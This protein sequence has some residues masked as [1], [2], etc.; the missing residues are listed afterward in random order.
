MK[1]TVSLAARLFIITAVAALL[2]AVVNGYTSPIIAERESMEYQEA[3]KVAFEEAE[4]FERID[5]GKLNKIKQENDNIDDISIAKK[6]GKEIGY[7]VKVIGTGGYGGDIIFVVG[8][9][10]ENMSIVGYDI[11]SSKET[12]G[13]GSKVGEEPFVSSLMGKKMDKHL[14]KKDKP[15]G[16][17]DIQAISG[18]TY[19]VNAILNG[20]NGTV[21]A[22]Q[23]I[24]Q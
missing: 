24:G 21:D 5:E 6:D 13:F 23:A 4:E 20:L 1:E 17:Y 3:L 22:L 10:K 16:D 8:V 14:D 11:L 19:S 7:V 9:E 18:T 15:E 2:L 12:P